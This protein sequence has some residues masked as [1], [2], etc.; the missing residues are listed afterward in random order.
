M[1][2]NEKS[3]TSAE[4]CSHRLLSDRQNTLKEESAQFLFLM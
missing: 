2:G 4:G 1:Q 3:F